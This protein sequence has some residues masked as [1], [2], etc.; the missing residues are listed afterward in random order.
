MNRL[1]YEAGN[2]EKVRTPFNIEKVIY[3]DRFL[4]E[5]KEKS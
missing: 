4:I 3:P 2:A 5:N 1:K